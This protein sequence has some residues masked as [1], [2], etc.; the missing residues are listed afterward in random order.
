MKLYTFRLGNITERRGHRH[1]CAHVAVTLWV[2]AT[3]QAAAVAELKKYAR[4]TRGGLALPYE[5]EVA[6]N[7][8]TI[9]TANI[10][11]EERCAS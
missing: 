10:I 8:N 5:M 9:S 3:S 2:K 7:A 11:K 4:Q 6:V 1:D